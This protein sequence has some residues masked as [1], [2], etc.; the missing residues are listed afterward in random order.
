MGVHQGSVLR[1]LLLIIVLEAPC[2]EFHGNAVC[3]ILDDQC[4]VYLT[5]GK[6]E[7]MEIRGGEEGPA[8]ERLW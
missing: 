3:R 2:R 4:R 6:V 1:Q 5:A 7:D 8:G